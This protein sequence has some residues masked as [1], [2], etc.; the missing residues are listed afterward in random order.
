[1]GSYLSS[2]SRSRKLAV[3]MCGFLDRYSKEAAGIC[4]RRDQFYFFVDDLTKISLKISHY[5]AWDQVLAT[6]MIRFASIRTGRRRSKYNSHEYGGQ[7]EVESPTPYELYESD[8]TPIFLPDTKIKKI[9]PSKR[10][11]KTCFVKNNGFYK[12]PE[13]QANTVAFLHPD[14]RKIFSFDGDHLTRNNRVVREFG[15]WVKEKLKIQ[16]A[17]MTYLSEKWDQIHSPEY[18]SAKKIFGS[19]S[20]L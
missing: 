5:H 7:V 11:F 16:D 3:K 17:F 6:S 8:A 19:E 12:F 1:M 9:L 15:P 4:L 10:Y 18:I 13:Y 20:L 14:Y 2:V